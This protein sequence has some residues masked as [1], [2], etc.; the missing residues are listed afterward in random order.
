MPV[1]YDKTDLSNRTSYQSFFFYWGQ[2][3][4][5]SAFL[6]GSSL[7]I[8]S[9][10]RNSKDLDKDFLNAKAEVDESRFRNLSC[11]F[12]SNDDSSKNNKFASAMLKHISAII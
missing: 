7:E 4:I 5:S 8:N 11:G 2:Y 12:K 10:I 1:K 6:G 9:T 3:V